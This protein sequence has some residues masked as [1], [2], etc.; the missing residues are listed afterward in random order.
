MFISSVPKVLG[1]LAARGALWCPASAPQLPCAGEDEFP[2][3][4]SVSAFHLCM[5]HYHLLIT[6]NK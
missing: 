3:C 2:P 1:S 5:A 4:F 6:R